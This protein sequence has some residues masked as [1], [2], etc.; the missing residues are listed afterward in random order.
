MRFFAIAVLLFHS[1]LCKRCNDEHEDCPDWADDGECKSNPTFMLEA[2]RKSCKVCADSKRK[3]PHT[4][5]GQ[6]QQQQQ[7]PQPQQPAK[8]AKV[9]EPGEERTEAQQV[10]PNA[11]RLAAE[12][13]GEGAYSLRL[14]LLL[15]SG[16]MHRG[17]HNLLD[18]AKRCNRS[19]TCLGFSIQ[20]PAT[21]PS[22]FPAGEVR[23]SFASKSGQPEG[24]TAASVNE[25]LG[26]VSF[27]KDGQRQCDGATCDG[28]S[29]LA[30][31][32]ASFHIRS[33]ELFAER[34]ARGAPGVISQVEHALASGA[35]RKLAYMLRAPAHLLLEKIH[36][37]K[38][39][40]GEVLSADPVHEDALALQVSVDTGS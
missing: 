34:G 5:E 12:L 28:A 31:Q 8:K 36:A 40:L 19:K 32:M 20:V 14:G 13:L 9:S 3:K 21:R 33:A 17:D 16:R 22:P 38:Q 4:D 18:A 39:D 2:C 30:T 10:K 6:Q 15:Q 29:A 11:V 7:Q 27:V 23:V 1:S 37:C 24:L 35:N 26:W 25:T